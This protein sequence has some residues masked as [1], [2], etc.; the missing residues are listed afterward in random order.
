MQQY[1]DNEE[2]IAVLCTNIYVSD[3]TNKIKTALRAGHKG[4]GAMAAE[5]AVRFGLFMSSEA[6]SAW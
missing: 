2:F 6:A 3:R 1:D 4:F 5:D